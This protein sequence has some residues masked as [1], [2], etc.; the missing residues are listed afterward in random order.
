MRTHKPKLTFYITLAFLIYGLLLATD[1]FA[2]EASWVEEAA[3]LERA[4]FGHLP[5]ACAGREIVVRVKDLGASIAGLGHIGG[6]CAMS[7]DVHH[8]AD[9]CLFITVWAHERAHLRRDDAWHS[10]D[11]GSVL[12]WNTGNRVRDRCESVADRITRAE[13][14]DALRAKLGS[15]WRVRTYGAILDEYG[16]QLNLMAKATRG[17]GDKRRVRTYIAWREVGTIYTQRWP[18]G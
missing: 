12:F 17:R 4:E 5:D 1:G 9:R 11:E 13:V 10:Q 2:Y 7:I 14:R 16:T 8:A 18:D 6:E 15:G 3:A